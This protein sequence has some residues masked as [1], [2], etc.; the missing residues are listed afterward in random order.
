MSGLDR[1]IAERN[2]QIS[3][4]NWSAGHDDQHTDEELVAAAIC[5]AGHPKDLRHPKDVPDMWPWSEGW[6]KPSRNKIRNLTKAGA[7]IAAEIDRLERRAG[8]K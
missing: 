6:W 3:D 1:I 8:A 2:R 7:L 5:Y 4:E